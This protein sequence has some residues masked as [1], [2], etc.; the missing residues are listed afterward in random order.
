MRAV[1][2]DLRKEE[3]LLLYASRYTI[4]DDTNLKIK[5]F[6]D[7]EIDWYYFMEIALKNKVL[8]LVW[9]NLKNNGFRK[10]DFVPYRLQQVFDFHYFGTGIRN[11]VYYSEMEKIIDALNS[12]GIIA[13]RLK[14]AYLLPEIYREFSVRTINDLDLMI[15]HSDIPEVKKIMRDLGY[16]EGDYN[17]E[18]KS[19]VPSDRHKRVL[20]ATQMNTIHPLKKLSDSEFVKYFEFDFSFSLGFDLKIDPV[21]E[22]LD[23]ADRSNKFGDLKPAH[24]FIH[25]CC[26]HYKEATNVAWMMFNSDIN[27]IKFCDTREYILNRM[28]DNS[29]LEAI[30]FAK[31]HG[32][33]KAV[34]F[35]L[36]YLKSIYN[37]GYEASKL[38]LLDIDDEEFINEFG[39]RD[40]DV[41]KTRAKSHWDRIFQSNTDEIDTKPKFDGLVDF[42]S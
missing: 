18:N 37:D 15:Y 7:K 11:K 10:D 29:F 22:M 28:D 17:D 4:S 26:H 12:N 42:K 2:D 38:E 16:I 27:L 24:F 36:F 13:S 8:P 21:S 20:W 19:I 32:Y 34:Y 35:V 41:V 3:Q 5:S 6:L 25:Q 33:E 40:F 14:G 23:S 30:D 9:H 1:F 39:S 31:R